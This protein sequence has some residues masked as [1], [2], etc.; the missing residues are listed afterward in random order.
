MKITIKKL[1]QGL[2]IGIVPSFVSLFIWNFKEV[3][4]RMSAPWFISIL[5]V[6]TTIGLA[7]ALKMWFIEQV[8][9]RFN[10]TK[11]AFETGLIWYIELLIIYYIVAI[12]IYNNPIYKFYPAIILLSIIIIISTTIGR[13]IDQRKQ[14]I[15]L[16]SNQ[17]KSHK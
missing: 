4:Y 9:R 7:I 3:T 14:K 12:V 10:A 6:A 8:D 11:E 13:I 2:I 15:C 16:E 5:T 17:N 1:L